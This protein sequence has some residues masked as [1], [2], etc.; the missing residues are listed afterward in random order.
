[1]CS[2]LRSAPQGVIADGR[3]HVEATTSAEPSTTALGDQ[4]GYGMVQYPPV[5]HRSVVHVFSSRVD[6]DAVQNG[7]GTVLVVVATG[8]LEVTTTQ[9]FGAD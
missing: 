3:S 7:A 2:V 8:F 6:H 5:L 1:M 4:A 9:L